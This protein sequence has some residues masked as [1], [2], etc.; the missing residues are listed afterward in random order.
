MKKLITFLTLGLLLIAGQ[1]WG[2]GLHLT[3]LTPADSRSS[4][5]SGSSWLAFDGQDFSA[6]AGKPFEIILT[7]SS[8]YRARGIAGSV[9]S[10][11]TLGGELLPN[12]SF[13]ADTTGWNEVNT[14]TVDSVA[15]SVTSLKLASSKKMVVAE[16]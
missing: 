8:G 12:P 9:G 2:V 4:F 13:D 10:G 1:A 6:Y 14:S 5:A 15:G 7:D 16:P 11:E 3:G